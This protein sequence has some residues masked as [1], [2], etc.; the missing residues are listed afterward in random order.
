V[1][2]T[3]KARSQ[4]RMASTQDT[5]L[6]FFLLRPVWIGHNVCMLGAL[7]SFQAYPL[8]LTLLVSTVLLGFARGRHHRAAGESQAGGMRNKGLRCWW[9]SESIDREALLASQRTDLL[10]GYMSCLTGRR[11]SYRITNTN[12]KK[13]C[14]PQCLRLRRFS[15][16]ATLP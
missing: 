3:S 12:A 13:G 7:E 16:R 15:R 1:I 10:V 6:A 4:Y 8:L 14:L 2:N 5:F 9:V 11:D